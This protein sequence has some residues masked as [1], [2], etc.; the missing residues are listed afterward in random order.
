MSDILFALFMPI[1]V[2][3]IVIVLMIFIKNLLENIFSIHQ[4]SSLLK[5]FIIYITI[6]LPVSIVYIAY[7]FLYIKKISIAGEDVSELYY[8]RDK[9][10]ANSTD[11]GNNAVFIILLILWITGI[12]ILGVIRI[13]K[14]NIFLK[15]LEKLSES[16]DDNTSI[17]IKKR[18]IKELGIKRDVKLF[19]NSIVPSPFIIGFMK[20]KI[21]LPDNK[22]SGLETE[23][24]L[25]H[26]LTHLTSNDYIYRK[27]IFFLSVIY[28]FNPVVYILSNRFIEIN[29]M[30]CDKQV[31]RIY[32]KKE[33]LAYMKLLCEMACDKQDTVNIGN[34][35]YLKGKA[36][37]NFERRLRNIMKTEKVVGK[38]SYIF[39]SILV[40]GACP[41]VSYAATNAVIDFQSNVVAAVTEDTDI[42]DGY[43][44][45]F[46][47]AQ[48]DVNESVSVLELNEMLVPIGINY[49]DADIRRNTGAATEAVYLSK[50]QTIEYSL[51]TNNSNNRFT[52]GLINQRGRRI[53]S[54]S[55][56]KGQIF[57]KYTVNRSG[58]YRI[59]ISNNSRKTIHVSGHFFINN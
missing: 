26:E 20:P 1:I 29:E 54:V 48:D 6:S 42:S 43:E 35:I 5:G 9:T 52:A 25:R 33:K 45:I 11:L 30:A 13:F 46:E 53:G 24:I 19:T 51:Q 14:E 16:V 12:L 3:N 36:E 57:Y 47:E 8:I 38:L 44:P 37:R 56:K 40:L 27:L 23:F 32:K 2:L 50:G 31:L 18:L 4:L 39:V 7:R 59:Y 10:V 17:E 55:S 58:M 41:V 21:F 49:V 15:K 34:I 28:W 22:F